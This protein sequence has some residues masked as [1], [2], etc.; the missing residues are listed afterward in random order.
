MVQNRP[1][2]TFATH[3][4][5]VLGVLVTAFPIY[6]ALVASTHELKT[7]LQS[8]PLIP[9]PKAVENYADALAGFLVL[10][11]VLPEGEPAATANLFYVAE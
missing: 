5:L 6:L 10:E 9:G 11:E 7:I 2:L 3:S 1:W 4:I 8:V